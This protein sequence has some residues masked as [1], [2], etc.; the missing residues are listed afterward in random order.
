MIIVRNSIIPFPGFKAI[1]IFGILFCRKNANISE[2]DINH[3]SIH[4]KQMVEMLFIPY[5][6]WYGIEYLVRLIKYRTNHSAYKKI[7][8]EQE[9]Y[10]FQYDLGYLK[11]RKHYAWF[12]YLKN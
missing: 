7:S 6:I 8:F 4:T 2:K 3:E 11:H 10:A 9:A 5:Y 12:K 1:N